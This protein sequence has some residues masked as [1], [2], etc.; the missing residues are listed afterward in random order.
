MGVCYE[1]LYTGLVREEVGRLGANLLVTISN[2]SWYGRA[3]AQEQHLA[4]AVLRSV[5]TRRDLLRA[6]ITGITAIV[7]GLGRIRGE[8]PADRAATLRGT[9]RLRS[10]NTAWTSW[11]Y[12]LP[13]VADAAAAAV[14]LFA[15]A[16]P[17]RSRAGG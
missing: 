1:I 13:R 17:R 9:A 16:R 12:V 15:L 4:G 8:L 5:E 6:A 3:G 7:D 2:D 10:E 14:L 11:G